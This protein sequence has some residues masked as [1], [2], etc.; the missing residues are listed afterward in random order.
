MGGGGGGSEEEEKGRERKRARQRELGG[1]GSG[2]VRPCWAT[3]MWR[4][5]TWTPKPGKTRSKPSRGGGGVI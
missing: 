5:L 1:G 4:G 3:V 2:F